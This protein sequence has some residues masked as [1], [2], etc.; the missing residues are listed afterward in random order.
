MPDSIKFFNV[1]RGISQVQDHSCI[2]RPCG[3]IVRSLHCQFRSMVLRNL[4]ACGDS[5]CAWM[6]S[7][8]C[9]SKSEIPWWSHCLKWCL[10]VSLTFLDVML[11][12]WPWNRSMRLITWEPIPY[13]LYIINIILLKFYSTNICC[14]S[15]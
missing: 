10:I 6:T 11:Y 8:M 12:R 5:G 2:L 1:A 4:N 3:A 15:F 7:T 14:S 9:I 13:P